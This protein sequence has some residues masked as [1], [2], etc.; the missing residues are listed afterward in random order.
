MQIAN[1]HSPSLACDWSLFRDILV[2]D[3]RKPG[4]WFWGWVWS[5]IRRGGR[6]LDIFSPKTILEAFGDPLFTELLSA[7]FQC[8]V[9][10]PCAVLSLLPFIIFEFI[11]VS[12]SLWIHC[13]YHM[14]QCPLTTLHFCLTS[15]QH[16]K[17]RTLLLFLCVN[18]V[19]CAMDIRL[20]NHL[21]F[22][23]HTLA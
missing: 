1:I 12:S 5:Q 20:S 11:H 10:S 13:F 15:S 19:L 8:L 4:D 21:I 22:Q 16:S 23:F 14:C 17:L 6:W 2:A 18:S 9:S 7:F 3:L